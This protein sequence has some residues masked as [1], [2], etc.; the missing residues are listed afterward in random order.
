MAFYNGKLG[1]AVTFQ[2]PAQDP[3][4]AIMRRDGAQLFVK[5]VTPG[6]R[7]LK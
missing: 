7:V 2:E 5:A 3:F 1:F 4:F 6:R